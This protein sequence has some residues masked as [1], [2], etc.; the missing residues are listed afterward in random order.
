MPNENIQ[1]I[2]SDLPEIQRIALR[3]WQ[4]NPLLSTVLAMAQSLDEIARWAGSAHQLAQQPPATAET[5]AAGES[6]PT[7]LKPKR[8]G[9]G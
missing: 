5:P 3:P 9:E 7:P 4:Q 6:E 8:A 1:K 2:L